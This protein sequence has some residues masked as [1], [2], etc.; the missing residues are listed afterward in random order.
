MC[1]SGEASTILAATGL[2][3]T[4]YFFYKKEPAALCYALGFFS[5]MEALQA[6][7]YT[8]IDQCDAPGNQIATF[9]GYVHI[10]F[11]PFFINAVALYFIPEQIRS[12]IATLVY[13][14]CFAATICL[15][16]R[17]YPFDWAPACYEVKARFMIP[18]RF[19][20]SFTSPFCGQ[21]ICSVSGAW[22]I[23]WEAPTMANQMLYN[24]YALT[25]FGLPI[26]YGSWKMTGYHLVTGPLLAFLTTENPNEWAAVWCLYSIAL[27]FLLV[28]SPI[29][30]Y[31]HVRHWF[32]WRYVQ[33]E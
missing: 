13:S 7:T 20:D 3:S 29:R 17:L 28:K 18:N 11:Q 32:W 10:A 24:L 16:V 6:Y 5:L 22:H 21:R 33:P 2:S 23:A 8:V 31:L 14:L 9:L 1:W 12:R 19:F 26:L 4:A 25:T 30:G 15:L 27:V